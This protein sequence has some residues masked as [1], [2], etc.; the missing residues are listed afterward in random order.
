LAPRPASALDFK[1]IE[2]SRYKYL[3]ELFGGDPKKFAAYLEINPSRL[4]NPNHCRA[5]LVTGDVTGGDA[6]R[7]LAAV[8]QSQG[9]LAALYLDSGGGDTGVGYHVMYLT[10]SFWLKTFAETAYAPDFYLPPLA[11]G[12]A[13]PPQ[14]WND[15][16]NGDDRRRM[17]AQAGKLALVTG[18]EKYLDT[19]RLLPPGPDPENSCASACSDIFVGGAQRVGKV[20]VHH[21]RKTN[22]T[23]WLNLQMT[24]KDTDTDLQGDL[25]HQMRMLQYMDSGAAIIDAARETTSHTVSQAVAMRHPRYVTDYLLYRCGA[26]LELLEN[27]ERRLAVTID[28]LASP[29]YG[30]STRIDSLRVARAMVHEERRL[31]VQCVAAAHERDRLAAYDKLCGRKCDVPKV[32]EMAARMRD[33]EPQ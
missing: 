32:V 12:P 21:T 31:Q 8:S 27:I 13:A 20:L 3:F 4:P 6:E 11:S 14:Q 28:A 19:Q 30:Q 7:F 2:A 22:D 1:C 29:K 16:L 9:W 33:G 10:R 17:L 25:A 18:W 26:E 23:Q 5:A 15:R 24:M